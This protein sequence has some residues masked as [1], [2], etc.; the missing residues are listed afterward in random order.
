MSKM[1]GGSFGIP[2]ARQYV[3]SALRYV[4]YSRQTAGYFSHSIQVIISQFMTFISPKG[5]EF[6]IK[7]VMR[8][9]HN[10]QVKEGTYT[11]A[12]K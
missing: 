12:K 6:L 1:E 2:T 7:K 9:A 3:E 4:G 5:T 8:A 10:K 11:P